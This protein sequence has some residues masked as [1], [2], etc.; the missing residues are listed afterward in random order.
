[1]LCWSYLDIS[2]KK[3]CEFFNPQRIFFMIILPYVFSL[4]MEWLHTIC[5]KNTSQICFPDVVVIL[6]LIPKTQRRPLRKHTCWTNETRKRK[7][8]IKNKK[9]Q[10]Q[11]KQTFVYSAGRV[12]N[13]L[14]LVI[15]ACINIEIEQDLLLLLTSISFLLLL[16]IILD[17]S[18]HTLLILFPFKLSHINKG[19]CIEDWEVVVL[20]MEK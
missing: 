8:K 18:Y 3:L 2:I 5:R 10:Q 6:N 19:K 13:L 20:K 12:F 9:Y 17:T 4:N 16:I 15:V 1:M 14:L 7:K 11:Q